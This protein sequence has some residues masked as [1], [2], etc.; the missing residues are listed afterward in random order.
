MTPNTPPNKQQNGF[1]TMTFKYWNG[2]P[3]PLTLTPLNIFGIIS[4]PNFS[5]MKHHLKEYM[6]YGRG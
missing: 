3:N 1:L 6:N 5:N 2:L 4:S